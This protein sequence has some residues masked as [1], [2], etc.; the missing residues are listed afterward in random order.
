M[1]SGLFF[2][3][4]G[5]QPIENAFQSEKSGFLYRG[6]P[7]AASSFRQPRASGYPRRQVWDNRPK[8]KHSEDGFRLV[9][10]RDM[11]AATYWWQKNYDAA[12]LEMDSAQLPSRVKDALTSIQERLETR[13]EQGGIEYRVIV[14]A[15]KWLGM[16]KATRR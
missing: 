15:R 1:A 11:S 14:E 2:C 16:L 4:F 3:D 7:E 8:G 5:V 10:R 6:T 12:V 9:E 13:I